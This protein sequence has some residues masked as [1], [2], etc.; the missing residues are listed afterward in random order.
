MV[1]KS[2]EDLLLNPHIKA[3]IDTERARHREDRVDSILARDTAIKRLGGRCIDF[4][5]D[6]TAPIVWEIPASGGAFVIADDDPERDELFAR[7]RE[8][9]DASVYPE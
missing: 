3:Q 9:A 8:A 2:P 7:M 6:V 5:H 1:R 4:I